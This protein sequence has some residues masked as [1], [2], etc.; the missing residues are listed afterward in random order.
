MAD[1][2]GTHGFRKEITIQDTNVDSNLTDFPCYVDVSNDA[3][4]HE[5]RADGYDIRFTSSDESTLLKYEREY[6]TGGNGS[7]ATAHFWVKVPSILAS[8]GA[9]IYCYYGDADASD[10]EDAANVWDSNFKAVWHMNQSRQQGRYGKHKISMVLMI[11]LI[12][13]LTYH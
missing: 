9:T 2:Y 8:G 11:I 3:D 12:V 5:A 1:L 10:G 4:F 13:E 6:W 7:A